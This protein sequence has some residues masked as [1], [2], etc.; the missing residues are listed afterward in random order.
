MLEKTKYGFHLE[1][2]MIIDAND[3]HLIWTK[4]NKTYKSDYDDLIAAYE[5]IEKI[6]HI[7]WTHR[8]TD[9]ECLG[10]IIETIGLKVKGKR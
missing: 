1:N 6:K 2:N 7:I 4:G 9:E 3:D 10:H 5:N 8:F